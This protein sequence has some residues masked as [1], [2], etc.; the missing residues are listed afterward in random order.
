RI[1]ARLAPEGPELRIDGARGPAR[2]AL[3][4]LEGRLEGAGAQQGR[5]QLLGAPATRPGRDEG[6]S[7]AGRRRL[8]IRGDVHDGGIDAD[9][10]EPLQDDR[11]EERLGELQVV[12]ARHEHRESGLDRAPEAV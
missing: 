10:A 5:D 1:E 7:T 11:I 8:K 6:G 4:V 2:V 9:G 12:A 3:A